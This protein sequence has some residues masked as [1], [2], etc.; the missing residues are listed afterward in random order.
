[1][2]KSKYN[3][4][5]PDDVVKIYGADCFRMYEMFLGPIE[6]SK[7]WD[8]KGIDGVSKFLKR[9]W[10]LYCH[11]D[12]W[13]VHQNGE[14]D[15]DSLRILHQT[16]QRIRDDINRFSIN[17]CVSHF[18]ICV[19]ELK[20]LDCHHQAILEPLV[21]L[22][23]PFAPHISEELWHLLG[24]ESSVHHAD[25]PEVIDAYLVADEV[26]YPVSVNGKRRAEMTVPTD[27]DAKR[28]EELA[29]AMPEI[30]KWIE[31]LTIRKM[32][33]VPGRMINIVVG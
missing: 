28:L 7:P 2:S 20:R 30:G 5:N 13:L 27:T 22:L 11:Q 3:V 25:Y 21:R 4:I 29:L 1:M 33:V 14:P 18:M 31:G 15:R 12:Q 8:T 16:I 26:T 6:Q 17:T 23:A 24:M 10:S 9:F 32:I 19:N